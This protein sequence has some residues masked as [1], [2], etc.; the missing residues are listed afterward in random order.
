MPSVITLRTGGDVYCCSVRIDV[1]GLLCAGKPTVRTHLRHPAAAGCRCDTE[2]RQ[3]AGSVVTSSMVNS[4][5]AARVLT[6]SGNIESAASIRPGRRSAL[7]QQ[8]AVC[9]ACQHLPK[10][11]CEVTP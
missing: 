6:T 3:T 7:P 5:L 11:H 2:A 10:V 1:Q 9:R 8:T 4:I